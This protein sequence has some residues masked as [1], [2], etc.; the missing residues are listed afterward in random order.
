M[1]LSAARA[2]VTAWLLAACAQSSAPPASIA[3]AAP[4]ETPPTVVATTDA[5]DAAA[6][7]VALAPRAEGAWGIAVAPADVSSPRPL[8]VYLHGMWASPEDSCPFFERA[9][10]TRGFLVCPRGTTKLAYG[11]T[12]TGPFAA[13]RARVD[14]ATTHADAL[15]PGAAAQTDGTLLGFSIGAKTAVDIA[16]AEPGRW[17]GLVLMSMDLHLDAPKLAAAGVKRIV[18]AAADDD[19]ARLSMQRTTTA[20]VAAGCDARFVSLGRVGHHFPK[21]MD[22]KMVEAVA[23]VRGDK[24]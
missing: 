5:A 20:L 9:S 13:V 6:P 1:M 15:A 17:I 16:L 2:V 11:G 18:L 21:D 7:R 22:T 19:G 8:L 14:D 3:T 24:G 10:S 23:W 4:V 12:W